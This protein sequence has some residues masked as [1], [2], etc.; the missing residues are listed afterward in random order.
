MQTPRQILVLAM[1]RSGSSALTSLIEAMGAYVGAPDDLLQPAGTNPLGFWERRD[2]HSLCRRMF[3]ARD[4]AWW[5]VSGLAAHPLFAAA[6]GKQR[7]Q[8]DQILEKLGAGR[9]WVIKDPML[10]FAADAFLPHCPAPALII[11]VRH[12]LEVA[13]SLE[14]RNGFPVELGL[15]LWESYVAHALGA[16]TRAPS[17]LLTHASLIRRPHLVS[18]Q[19]ADALPDSGL[20][21]LKRTVARELIRPDL[22]NQVAIRSDMTLLTRSQRQLWATVRHLAEGLGPSLEP[23]GLEEFEAREAARRAEIEASAG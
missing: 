20:S 10:C 15:A 18:R 21:H 7:A 23:A 17:L 3:K 5:R 22:R 8:L 12:P 4:A 9:T 19:I 14:S 16:R 11:L 13:R 6:P 2:V 1:H